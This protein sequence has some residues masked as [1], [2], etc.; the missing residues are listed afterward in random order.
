MNEN[1]FAQTL[2]KNPRHDDLYLVEF[3]KSG[4]TWLSFIFANIVL[5]ENKVDK[6]INFYNFTDWIPD[7]HAMRDLAYDTNLFRGVRV[8]KSHSEYN[9]FYNKV[10]YLVRDP[11]DV[12][13]SYYNFLTQ[14][15]AFKGNFEEFLVDKKSG[16]FAWSHH[17]RSWMSSPASV[18]FIWI[19]YEDLRSDA[20]ETLR[21]LFKICG[22]NISENVIKESIQRSAME[23]MRE[24]EIEYHFGNRPHLR[25]FQFV[26]KKIGLS[27]DMVTHSQRQIIKSHL[28]GLEFLGYGFDY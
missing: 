16:I 8:I 14:Q 21:R 4:V 1:F 12:M 24:L 11:L 7:I 18:S 19:K 2:P 26:G 23:N 25:N 6:I 13:I 27:R 3:P 5:I 28:S 17:I 22:E 15:E 9:P 20:M 10:I